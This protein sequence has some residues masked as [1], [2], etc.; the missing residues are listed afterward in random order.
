[1][2]FPSPALSGSGPKGVI[3][4]R[5]TLAGTPVNRESNHLMR[6]PLLLL[7]LAC[8]SAAAVPAPQDSGD[9]ASLERDVARLVN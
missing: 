8:A 6:S 4:A 3:S 5:A 9:L 2:R 7:I 1:M